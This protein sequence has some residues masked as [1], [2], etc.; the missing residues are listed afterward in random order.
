MA[1]K[2]DRIV[3]FDTRQPTTKLNLINVWGDKLKVLYLHLC[4]AYDHQ[5]WQSRGFGWG[6]YPQSH[7]T[8]VRGDQ[9]RPGEVMRHIKRNVALHQPTKSHDL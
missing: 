8:E 9:V 7:M 3:A 2:F 1:T 4:D 6:A 5:V